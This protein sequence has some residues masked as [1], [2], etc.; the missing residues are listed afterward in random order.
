MTDKTVINEILTNAFKGINAHVDPRNAIED[1][2]LEVAGKE[3][4][5]FSLYNL[6]DT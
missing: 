6:A 4:R 5:K 3:D 1:L 2:K